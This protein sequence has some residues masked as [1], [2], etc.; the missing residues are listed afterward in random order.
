MNK[1]I[2]YT[3]VFFILISSFANAKDITDSVFIDTMFLTDSI[4]KVISNS[5]QPGHGVDSFTNKDDL[6]FYYA[7]IGVINPTKKKYNV[8]MVCVD[9]KGN[10]ILQGTVKRSLSGFT[11]HVGG[12]IIKGYTQTLGMDPKIGAMVEG[13]IA[14]LRNGDYFIKLYFEKKLIG[15]TKFNYYVI[16]KKM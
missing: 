4:V 9:S 11:R 7:V 10:T 8:E 12:D 2:R 3:L 1:I 5:Y 14:P 13:Q 16:K 6:I 15:I